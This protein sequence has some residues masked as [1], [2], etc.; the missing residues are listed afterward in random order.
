MA[1]P[2]VFISL[3]THLIEL[4]MT[5]IPCFER[6]N[7]LK[8]L[9]SVT[10][11]QTQIAGHGGILKKEDGK[12]LKPIQLPPKGIR[13]KEFYLSL[14]NSKEDIDIE[15]RSHLP[16]FYGIDEIGFENGHTKTE[17]FIVLEDVAAEFHKPNIM[18]IKI[19]Q[20]T[21][22][23]DANSKKRQEEDAKYKGTKYP[24]GFSVLSMIVHSIQDNNQISTYGKSFGKNLETHNVN[25][26]PEIFFDVDRSGVVKELVQIVVSHIE[27]ILE[28]FEKQRK[29]HLY[30]SSLLIAYDSTVVK[31]FIN[32][33][34]DLKELKKAVNV[35]IIDFAHVFRNTDKDENFIYGLKNLITVFNN[36]L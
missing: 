29:Y 27:S 32:N 15:F 28:L 12:I 24:F 36:I 23:P 8:R 9:T 17:E 3:N 25:I 4:I 14:F 31:A 19:G 18:D 11:L 5:E 30:A 1:L 22:G 7:G 26:V 33:S 2:L 16:R 21:W 34:A 6:V 35:K 13:E 10:A 20:R